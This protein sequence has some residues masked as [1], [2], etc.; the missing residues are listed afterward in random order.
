LQERS[1]TRYA[2]SLVRRPPQRPEHRTAQ[3]LGRERV[4]RTDRL[5]PRSD[6][7]ADLRHDRLR[8]QAV[9]SPFV[10]KVHRKALEF[11][12]SSLSTIARRRR[13]RLVCS[14]RIH[15]AVSAPP[16][17]SAAPGIP[18]P[19]STSGLPCGLIPLDESRTASTSSETG[20]GSPGP[21]SSDAASIG[22]RTITT[23]RVFPARHHTKG[24]VTVAGHSRPLLATASMTKARVPV[25]TGLCTPSLPPGARVQTQ[26][27][28]ST[29]TPRSSELL[30]PV[31]WRRVPSSAA[32]HP[33]AA[34]TLLASATLDAPRLAR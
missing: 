1:G 19:R 18:R 23:G 31:Q 26:L 15:E 8:A 2:F 33:R 22:P 29:L 7:G 16:F 14:L 3:P 25:P 32:G 17:S 30:P 27:L 5:S 6:G 4:A 10:R 28:Q 11:G 9:T 24:S 13:S 21:S 34:H 12:C 20:F